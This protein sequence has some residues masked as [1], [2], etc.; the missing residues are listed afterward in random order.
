MG[1]NP[2]RGDL[3]ARIVVVCSCLTRV[4]ETIERSENRL[5]ECCIKE[6]E[7]QNETQTGPLAQAADDVRVEMEESES[8]SS[9]SDDPDG[10][11]VQPLEQAEK[12]GAQATP[13]EGNLAIIAEEEK[14]LQGDETP[15]TGDGQATETASITG[16]LQECR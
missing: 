12:E 13:S 15:E 9:S 3:E 10:L 2:Q 5:K 14:I 11:E 7:A 1:P 16:D 8:S 4:K 6:L